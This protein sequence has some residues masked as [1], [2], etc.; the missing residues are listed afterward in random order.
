M[1][2]KPTTLEATTTCVSLYDPALD[3]DKSQRQPAPVDGRERL[4]YQTTRLLEPSRWR[5]QLTVH[6]GQEPTEFVVGVVPPADLA[7]I[8]DECHALNEERE[9]TRTMYWRCFL[10]GLRDIRNGPTDGGKVPKIKRGD[11]EYVD[12]SWLAQTFSGALY[13][14]ATEIGQVIYAW[15]RFTV[16]DAKN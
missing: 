3:L 5:E 6:D 15:Q 13:H 12:P 10:T 16:A 1:A 9:Q 4:V 14:V 2:L 11:V 7:R 8:E